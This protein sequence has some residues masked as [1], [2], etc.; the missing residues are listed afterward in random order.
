LQDR[1][2][3]LLRQ[4]SYQ[5]SV[6]KNYTAQ[7]GNPIEF[8]IK[9][10]NSIQKIWNGNIFLYHFDPN[11]RFYIDIDVFKEWKFG[12]QIYYIKDDQGETLDHI[13]KN[14]RSKIRPIIFINKLFTDAEFRY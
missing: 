8:E 6:K 12:I 11:F 5:G 3:K 2:I 14:N 7:I 10:F 9:S 13:F 4:E 1:K